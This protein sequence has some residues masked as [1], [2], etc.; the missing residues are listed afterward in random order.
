MGVVFTA[1]FLLVVFQRLAEL[2]VARKNEKWMKDNGA[3]EAGQEHYKFIVFLHV[4]F[5]AA[6]FVE[7]AIRGFTLSSIWVVMLAIFLVAQIFRVWTMKSLGKF[8]NTKIIV[9]PEA[10][11]VS[12]GPY[13]FIRHPNYVIVAVEIIAFPLIFSSYLTALLFTLLNAFLILKIR[14]PAE[15]YALSKATNYRDSFSKD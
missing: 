5:L 10:N 12:S 11:V 9:L 8:W 3:F 13:R 2:V 7:G 1:F 4:A 15:E 6:V 14:I